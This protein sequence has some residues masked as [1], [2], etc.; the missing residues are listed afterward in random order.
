MTLTIHLGAHKTAT[1]HLQASWRGAMAELNRQGLYYAGPIDLRQ[2]RCPLTHALGDPRGSVREQRVRAYFDMVRDVYPR[3]L[4]SDENMLGGTRRDFFFGK[5]GQVYPDGVPR[6]RQMFSMLGDR[7]ATVALAVRDPASFQLS[8]FSL[9][10]MQGTELE[11]E[12]YLNGRLPWALS[13][14]ELARRILTL[15][16][17][18]RLVVWRYEDYD[19][20]RSRILTTLLS[21]QLA[22]YIPDPNP[23]NI[24]LSQPGYDWLIG[25][26]MTVTDADLR[27]LAAQAQQK[28]PRGQGYPA[29][30]LLSSEARARSAQVYQDDIR[31]LCQLPKV[32]F[33]QSS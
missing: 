30:D 32:E 5:A 10:V 23:V 19:R 18:R 31:Q 29:L 15:P 9:Q 12:G 24:G 28:Y 13:W 6:L 4:L 14:A 26:A 16:Q 21:S 17:V 22:P 27:D 25:Q 7:P 8:A 33:L 3:I 11:L 1:T 2:S 20:L